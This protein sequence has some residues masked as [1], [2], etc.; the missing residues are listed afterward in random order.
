[1]THH[2]NV[3]L[4]IALV[5]SLVGTAPIAAQARDQATVARNLVAAGLIK[6]GDKVLI[7]GSVRDAALMEDI[8]VETMKAGGQPVITLQSE[9]LLK[10]SYT[11]VPTSYDTLPPALDIAMINTFDA[12]ISLDVGETEGLLSS[13]PVSRREARAKA[14][15]PAREAQFKKVVRLVNLGNGLYPTATTA[16]R[17]G[18][19]QTRLAEVFWRAAAVPAA[20]LRARADGLRRVMAAGKSI[21]VTHPNGTNLTFAAD[22][23]RAIISDGALTP[24]KLQ[25]GSAAALTWLP[26]GE[27]VL[28]AMPG[29]ASGTLVID[30]E[31][32]DGKLVEG[33]TLRFANGKLTS[34]T[35]KSNLEAIKAFYDAASGAKDEFG[36]IDIGVNPETTVPVG[37]GRTVWG[38][39]GSIVFGIGDNRIFGGT[40]ASSF[41]L[42]PQLGGATVTVDGKPVIVNGTIR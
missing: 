1:M 31:L 24:E 19:P 29:T 22:Y 18:I 32:S 33:L 14:G 7:S 39:P 25:Q 17:L 30:R 3:H 11:D 35:A 2:R 9:T 40:N 38:A 16:T 6:P 28:P 37:T 10:R 36:F 4:T 15:E 12:Q 34:M 20:T 21:T 27:L 26:A 41:S 23:G 13:V 42:S 8:A 5:A